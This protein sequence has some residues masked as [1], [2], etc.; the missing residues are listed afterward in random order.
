MK[1][2][3]IAL[4]L[5][6]L[7]PTRS[8]LPDQNLLPTFATGSTLPPAAVPPD[9]HPDQPLL[10]FPSPFSYPLLLLLPFSLPTDPTLPSPPTSTVAG[11]QLTA[12]VVSPFFPSSS[13]PLFPFP[14]PTL[15]VLLPTHLA[16]GSRRSLPLLAAGQTSSSYLPLPSS[17]VAFMP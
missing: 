2:P 15:L 3:K 9:S 11:Q 5:L 10:S 4:S 7:L 12:A 13:F 17:P 6:F 8:S 16:T 1:L 14:F